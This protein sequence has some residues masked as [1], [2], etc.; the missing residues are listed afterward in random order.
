MVVTTVVAVAVSYGLR[1]L[2]HGEAIWRVVVMGLLI[3]AVFAGVFWAIGIDR[4][5]RHYVAQLVQSKLKLKK[6]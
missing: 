5:E 1:M 2:I 6:I 4:E 3:E